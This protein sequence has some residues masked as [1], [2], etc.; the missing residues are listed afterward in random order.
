VYFSLFIEVFREAYTRRFNKQTK[1][2]EAYMRGSGPGFIIAT[3]S[4]H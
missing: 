2:R 1:R 4:N 3:F